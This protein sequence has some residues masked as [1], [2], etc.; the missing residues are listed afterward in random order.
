ML[1]HVK[2]HYI[3]AWKEYL[4]IADRQMPVKTLYYDTKTQ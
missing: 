2:M 1:Y 3:G 4:Y